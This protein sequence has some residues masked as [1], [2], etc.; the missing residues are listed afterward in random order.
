MLR[1]SGMVLAAGLITGRIY[2]NSFLAGM[3]I[4]LCLTF[5]YP[6]Y[7]KAE[8]HK[9]KQEL[10]TQ[11]KDLLYSMSASMVLGRNMR[12]SLEESLSFWR[13]VY[14]E[15]D[16]IVCEVKIMLKEMEETNETDTKVLRDFAVRSG[17]PDIMDFVNV[18]ESCK[19]TGG[20]MPRAISRA[21]SVIGDKIAMEKEL[22]LALSEK[23]M[24]GRIVGVA[25]FLMTLAMKLMSPGYMAPIYGSSGG[26]VVAA[27]SLGLSAA[28]LIMIER[29][30]TIEF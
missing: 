12:Q 3:I 10:L 8:E 11:F 19:I 13:N 26:I 2:F 15:K 14:S 21:A 25:P 20:N 29:I 30:N 28:A 27:L 23:M 22:E 18:Y 9:R 4:S 16:P 6:L 17:L 24:E 7:S 5:A 1:F